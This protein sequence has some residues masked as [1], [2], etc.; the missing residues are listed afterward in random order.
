MVAP[1]LA[2]ADAAT[3]GSTM[4][5]SFKI[6][7]SHQEMERIIIELELI[8]KTQPG[9]WLPTTVR[10]AVPR[11]SARGGEAEKGVHASTGGDS[12][13]EYSPSSRVRRDDPKGG[14]PSGQ[15]PAVATRAPRASSPASSPL[16][17]R[18]DERARRRFF[19]SSP[20]S[21]TDSFP[22]SRTHASRSDARTQGIANML[23][24]ELGYE[25]QEEFE[26]A[27]KGSFADFIGALP[28]IETRKMESELQPGLVRD[29]FRV[30]PD[31]P[32]EQCTPQRLVLEIQSRADLWRILMLHPG[33]HVEI[34]ELE[35]EI[36]QDHK[37][38]VDSVYNHISASIFNLERHVELVGDAAERKGIQDAC[39]ALRRVLDLD[40]KAT[41][42]VTDPGGLSAFKPSEGVKVSALEDAAGQY[43][44]A[45]R[46]LAVPEHEKEMDKVD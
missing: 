8:Y 34:P 30:I 44:R 29:V 23:A 31:P 32:P 3:Y 40:E 27:L 19:S 10:A 39:D 35:F 42:I 43:D 6:D 21:A 5:D 2:T 33:A 37:R 4:L 41:F 14:G 36:G 28:H 1:D 11:N 7:I 17:T 20:A 12:A 38:R 25:D 16:G 26:D 45:A 22:H 18:G 13:R 46:A 9:Q 15:V 24:D